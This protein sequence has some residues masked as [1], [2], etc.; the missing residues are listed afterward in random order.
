MKLVGN[1]DGVGGKESDVTAKDE[2][3]GRNIYHLEGCVQYQ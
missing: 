1:K 2:V 3:P